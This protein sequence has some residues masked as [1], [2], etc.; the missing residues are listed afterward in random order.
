[1][2][3]NKAC[4]ET[5]VIGYKLDIKLH[6]IE[7]FM[8]GGAFFAPLVQVDRGGYVECPRLSTRGGRGSKLVQNWST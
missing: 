1:M 4:V 7:Y 8:G 3:K 5:S 2:I 6:F